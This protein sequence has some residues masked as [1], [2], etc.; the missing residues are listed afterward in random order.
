MV[1]GAQM[2]D[3]GT[4]L[5]ACFHALDKN[6]FPPESIWPYLF[7]E[8]EGGPRWSAI[9][10]TAA[11]RA[12]FDQRRPLAYHRITEAGYE[13]VD[14]VKRAIAQER[15]VCFGTMLDDSW[16][17]YDG[18]TVLT[19]ARP[20]HEI[21]GHA[22]VLAEYEGDE[23][24]GPNSWGAGWGAEGWYRAEAELIAHPSSSDFWIVQSAPLYVEV[25]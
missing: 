24:R 7:D 2:E 11:F 19:V 9:P 22:M 3:R 16:E 1:H 18:S 21:G 25:P 6:G 14:A 15:V 5:R 12:A 17:S 4:Y 8:V 23:F 10:S 13:R 20:R